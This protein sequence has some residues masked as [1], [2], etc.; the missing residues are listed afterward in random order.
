MKIRIGTRKS[1][2]ALIQTDMFIAAVKKEFPGIETEIVNISTKGDEIIDRPLEKI[3][4]KG[5]FTDA[6][7][8]ALL[9]KRIDFAVHSAKDMPSDITEGLCV[10]AVLRR[11]SPVDVTVFRKGFVPSDEM[12]IGT[13]STRRSYGISKLYAHAVLKD[14]RGNVDTRL[15]KLHNGEYDCI[16]LA[17]AGLERLGA[18]DDSRFDF[19]R[20]PTDIIMPAPCQGIIAIQSR[21]DEFAEI[22]SRIDHTD[23][24][25]AYETE[26][27]ILRLMGAGCSSPLGALAEI[28]GDRIDIQISTDQKSISSDGGDITKR[29]IIAE[30]L[31]KRICAERSSL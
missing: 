11:A 20:L 29:L 2:L 25:Y 6:I 8:S 26:R 22:L 5:V 16:I 1:R 18:F 17:A 12:I 24:M 13:S 21:R 3:G 9:E 27:A 15:N 31:V 4:G 7:E 23:T 28:K 30:R 19:V 10:G 14:I